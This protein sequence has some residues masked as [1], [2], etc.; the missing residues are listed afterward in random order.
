M[1]MGGSMLYAWGGY[2]DIRMAMIILAG[3]LFGVQIGAIGTTYV[4]DYTVKFIMAIIMLIVLFSRV[5]KMPVYLSDLNIIDK[6]SSTSSTVLSYMSN[7][8][9]IAAL[10]V[11]AIA[12]FVALIKGIREH[13][14]RT[15]EQDVMPA[16]TD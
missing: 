8:T 2:V 11:G 15:A 3:S 6:I 12:I 16:A 5:F 13:K 7:I 10:M 4:K 9:L 1:G 14:K